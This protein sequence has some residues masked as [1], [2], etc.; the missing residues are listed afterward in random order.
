VA[1]DFTSEPTK[2]TKTV[3]MKTTQS[4]LRFL[5]AGFSAASL[6]ALAPCSFAAS[7]PAA[8]ADQEAQLAKQL[9]NPVA[10][11]I[12]VPF[13][14]NWDFGSG[15]GSGQKFTLNFQPVVP[16]SISQDWNLIIRTILPIVDQTGVFGSGSGSQ[17]GLGNTTQSFFLSPK[18]PGPGGLI[19]GLGPV[20][21]Y[22]TAT[23]SLIGPEKWGLG[24]TLV[25]LVQKGGWTAGV[26]ANQIWSVGGDSNEQ[27]ISAAFLQPFVAYTTKTH[28]TFTFNTESTYDWENEQWSVPLNLMV[29]QIL[30]IGKLPVSL[31]V[32][33]RYYVESPSGGPEWG[34]RATFTLLF[35]TGHHEAPEPAAYRK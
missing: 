13:Q 14:A 21:Y 30:K 35:P 2:P 11:L 28:T 20:G 26:L 25:A 5:T 3:S 8:G 15:D 22:P 6:L 4:F 16:I 24:P 17:S 12:S 19:W 18:E 7:A 27:N 1:R 23:D 33:G 29:S 31:Q 32:G 10:A 34:I 9:S